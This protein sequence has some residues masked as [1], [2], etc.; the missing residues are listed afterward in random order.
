MFRHVVCLSAPFRA[1]CAPALLLLSLG[2]GACAT[3]DDG[4]EVAYSVTAKQNYEKG[5]A[6]LKDEN[7]IEADKFFRFVKSKFPFSKFSV[8]AELAM[9]DG[10]FQ[11]GE[12]QAAIDSYK[13]FI[14][15]HP[16]HDK[17][18]DGYVAYRIAQSY[19]QDMPDDWLILPPSY[20]KDQSAVRDALRELS[21]FLDKYPDSKYVEAATK[22]RSDVVRRL[23]E[24]EVYVARFYLDQGHPK[25][26]ILRLQ[27]A[28]ERFPD[29]GREA[30]LLLTM[31]QTHLE[32]GNP[33]SA[34]QTF[35]K[36]QA[37]YRGEPQGRRAGVY[38][39][40]IRQRFGASPQD[41]PKPTTS[42]NNPN[43]Q[44]PENG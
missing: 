31:G 43:S 41:K 13:A 3:D 39:N 38:L 40:F 22:D 16:T 33:L 1:A 44:P 28:V 7:Y 29:S 4:R 9:A 21:D 12:Y 6:E 20:E 18:E 37:N 10:K 24:H 25:A 15:L 35:E 19:V 8:L 2:L 14:R 34:K 26:A 17:V 27:G 5:L 30:E 36:V 32:M 42:Q 11:R 23:V